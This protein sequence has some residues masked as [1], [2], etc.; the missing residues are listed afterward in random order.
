M[1][2]NETT[3]ITA[4]AMLLIDTLKKIEKQKRKIE[5]KAMN[6]FAKQNEDIRKI[7]SSRMSEETRKDVMGMFKRYYAAKAKIE[8]L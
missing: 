1:T 4:A 5:N 6:F 3:T 2:K 8:K 7:V